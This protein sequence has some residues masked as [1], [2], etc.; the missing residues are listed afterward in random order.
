MVV[1]G[2]SGHAVSRF[3]PEFLECMG[4]S[5][6]APVETFIIIS[7]DPMGLPRDNLFMGKE[8]VGTQKKMVEG[9]G[10]RHS[11]GGTFYPSLAFVWEK[12]RVFFFM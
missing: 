12:A 4:E 7:K 8:F 5:G 10:I 6:D 11:S 2:Q 1:P 9:E 3:D